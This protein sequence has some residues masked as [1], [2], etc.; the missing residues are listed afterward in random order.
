MKTKSIEKALPN[1]IQVKL[2]VNKEDI[3]WVKADDILIDDKPLALHLEE[4]DKVIK[5]LEN[6]LLDFTKKYNELVD[7]FETNERELQEANKK[8]KDLMTFELIGD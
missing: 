6:H 8:I 4:K 3:Y 7:R 5:D 1:S 2:G